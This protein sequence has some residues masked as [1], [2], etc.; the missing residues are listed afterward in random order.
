M[1]YDIVYYSSL[2]VC[3]SLGR[4]Y[5]K[6]SD[7]EM[8]RNYGAGLGF[9]VCCLLCG[10]YLYHAI[11]MVWGNIVIIKCCER[12][13]VHQM[14]LGFTWLDL[15]YIHCNVD[16]AVYAIWVHQTIA[17][18]LVGLAFE[19]NSADMTK[20]E[21]KPGPS[22][23]KINIAD[24][25]SIHVEPYAVDIIAYAFFFVGLHKDSY[26]RW[27][28][29]ND[30][31][32][33]SLSSIGDCRTLTEQKLKKAFLSCIAYFL[34][35]MKYSPTV[36]NNEKFYEDY[37]VDIRYLYNIPQLLM[38]YLQC[39][40]INLLC[41][42]VA[43]ESGF[44]LYPAKCQPIPGYGPSTNLNLMKSAYGNEVFSDSPDA[45]IHYEFSFGMLKCYD[46]EKL[47][48]GPKMKNT[49]SSWDM[50]TRYWFFTNIYKRFSKSNAEVRSAS[51]FLVWTIWNGPFLSQ[52]IISTT[53][54]VY[55]QLESEYSELYNTS[56]AMK[57]P[58]DIGFSIMR[59]FCL[60]YL[61]PC[62]ILNN[63]ATLLKYYGSIFWVYHV[64]LVVLTVG[65]V[66]MHKTRTNKIVHTSTL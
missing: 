49:I 56:G 45:L 36:Y 59:V 64:I 51:S 17:L 53:L 10:R 28:V 58:W 44:G 20:L 34:L 43:V 47:I 60:I 22:S 32:R 2:L 14:S 11:I 8:K 65:A 9:L 40:I 16:D 41:T 31:F 26:Y 23:V 4:N 12:R 35:R 7:I 25:D 1:W 42:S 61:T 18:R 30:H 39:Q 52:I 55:M 46:N 50:P 19:L 33:N 38:Y 48:F 5:R 21:Q 63:S 57:L 29:F 3:I 66:V 13:Y 54:W 27:A 15:L 37:A 6:I 24:V 62:F